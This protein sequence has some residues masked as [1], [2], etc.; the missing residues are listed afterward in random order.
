MKS[1]GFLLLMSALL[2]LW[3]QEPTFME[4]ATH[5]GSGQNYSRAVWFD[6]ETVF[7][8]AYGFT[9]RQA[10]LGEVSLTDAGVTGGG[11]RVK[12]RF[13]QWDSGPIDTWRMSVQGGM[14]WRDGRDP[15]PRLGVVST[16]IRGR[17]GVNAQVDV[18]AAVPGKER[19]ALNASHL[20]RIHPARYTMTTAGAWYTM[21]ESLNTVSPD[22][23]V[24]GD[25]AAGL[26]YE[27]RRWAAEV[28][29]RWLDED[30]LRA[31]VGV[32]M[33]W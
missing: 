15:G 30:T 2:P 33:L 16:T 23:D 18:N 25:V 6:G 13:W 4:A 22:G 14:D 1:L 8:H 20:Y 5:P 29:L 26:L 17:H 28:S 32:R 24:R 21:L 31:G 19:I 10:L 9:A 12:Q 7:K 11:V 27:A 3:G